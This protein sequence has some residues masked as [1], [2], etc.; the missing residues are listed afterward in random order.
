MK[1]EEGWVEGWREGMK[2]RGQPQDHT[3]NRPH[4][5]RGQE[6]PETERYEVTRTGRGK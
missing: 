4:T 2:G 5:P 1:G 3:V 6:G